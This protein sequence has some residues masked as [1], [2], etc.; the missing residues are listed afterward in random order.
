M[1]ERII[2]G[3]T[4]TIPMVMPEYHP[5]AADINEAIDTG[6]ASC[7]ARAY[8]SALLLRDALPNDRL[9]GIEFGYAP[10]HGE[11]FQGNEGAY[12][13]MGHAVTR[14]YIPEQRPLIIESYTDGSMEVFPQDRNYDT[15][16]WN[17]NTKE[18]YEQ[19]LAIADI[20][21]SIRDA[22]ITRCFYKQLQTAAA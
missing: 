21:T 5:D 3:A 2:D 12:I 6:V 10:E 16:I 17:I 20:D 1:L 22:D 7:A 4:L 8:M 11:D 18:G 13:K 14:L 19:Y 9:Y 15:F